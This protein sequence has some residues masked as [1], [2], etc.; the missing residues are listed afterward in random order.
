MGRCADFDDFAKLFSDSVRLQNV[1]NGLKKL[2]DG[3]PINTRDRDN[4][5]WG[6]KLLC[7]MD[8]DSARYFKKRSPEMCVVGTRL[9]PW[10]YDVLIKLEFFDY[11]TFLSQSY[12]VM[13]DSKA[14]KSGLE[15]GLYGAYSIF[16]QMT[17]IALGRLQSLEMSAYD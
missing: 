1:A 14:R 2:I 17:D 4:L 11:K 16:N 5:K 9:A 10:F 15:R 12:K 13:M 8:Y 7:E 6:A 3:Q